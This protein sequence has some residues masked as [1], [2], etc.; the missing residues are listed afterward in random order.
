MGRPKNSKDKKKRKRKTI[1]S[2]TQERDLIREYELG[3]RTS[4]LSKKYRVTKSYISNMF[5][6]RSISK[7]INLSIIK[8]WDTV[9][10]VNVLDKNIS[11][12]Y[13]IYFINKKNHND[14]KLYIGSSVD[15]KIRLRSHLRELKNN[16]HNSSSLLE[17][18]HNQNYVLSYAIVERCSEDKILQKEAFYLHLFNPSCLLNSWKSMDEETLRPWLEKAITYDAYAKN[19]TINT[20]TGCKESNNVHKKGYGRM[21]VTIGES[22]D[23]GQTKYFYKHRIAYW[24]KHREYPE[25]IRHKCNNPKCYNPDHLEKGNYRDNN[26]DKRG[27]FPEIFE[28][29]WLELNGDLSKLTKYFSDRWRGKKVSNAIY[30]WEKK[31]GLR[32]KY[33]EILD[34]NSN[35]RFSLSYQ[36]LGRSKKKKKPSAN[37]KV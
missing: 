7:R 6:L 26:L 3:E 36:K 12:V 18:F 8:K 2:G 24:E 27:N 25:L 33:P 10:N 14:I 19:Y 4:V 32:K 1:L 9:N 29:K 20:I 5:R 23:Q 16:S 15:I 17:Y 21:S 34:A 37:L 35:R 30:M 11:G 31:L 13:S 22:K 28:Q